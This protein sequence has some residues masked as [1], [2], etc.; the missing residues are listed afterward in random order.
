MI[1]C[2]F[3]YIHWTSLGQC[4]C[5]GTRIFVESAIYDEFVERSTERAKKRTVGDPFGSAE[6]GPQIDATQM[7]KILQLIETG[8]A[9]GARMTTGGKRVGEKGKYGIVMG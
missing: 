1:S 3:G 9:Q 7:G 8:N 5:A 4:C 2:F 6:Q